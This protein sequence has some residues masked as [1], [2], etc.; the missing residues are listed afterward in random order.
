MQF[1]E[2]VFL[3]APHEGEN[4]ICLPKVLDHGTTTNHPI[5]WPVST[6]PL[7]FHDDGPIT[8][9]DL[10]A[11]KQTQPMC[12]L[13]MENEKDPPAQNLSTV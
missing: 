3:F 9:L 8:Q 13:P 4:G 11:G 5:Q 1:Y 6:Y 12:T 2:E 10:L 7:H